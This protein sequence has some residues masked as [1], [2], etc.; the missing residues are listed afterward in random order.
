MREQ[1]PSNLF[2]VGNEDNGK[3]LDLYLAAVSA[4]L[5]RSR[6]QKL[7]EE[8]L[9]RVNDQPCTD[10]N[11]RVQE[12]D[13]VTYSLPALQAIE[14]GPEEIALDVVYEDH[15]LLVINKPREMVVHPAPGHSDGT[16]VNSLL[17][18]CNDLSGIGGAMRPGIVHRLD[19]DTSGLL[20]VAKNDNAHTSL[21]AQLKDRT[22]HRDYLAL[23]CGRVKPSAG[24]IEAPVGRH[25]HNRKKMAVI[26]GG[27]Q[28]V[29]RYRV[30]KEY[31]N[32]SLLKLKLETGRTHQIRVHLAYINYPVVGDYTYG[33]GICA[34]L[35]AEMIF[36]HAL[37]AYRLSFIHPHSQ[38]KLEL[39]VPLPPEFR[40]ILHYLAK[41]I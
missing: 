39:K 16:L 10:K 19:K 4:E 33:P 36:C 9:V 17:Y 38:E 34:G 21:S 28:A 2:N 14:A 8:G 5:S 13:R 22:M 29:T 3:R 1:Q 27:R 41:K 30:L 7:I 6:V 11:Y 20:I 23:V 12:G 24:R 31:D 26:A 25:P 37:H 40:T 15:D 35:P 32:F 18:Y